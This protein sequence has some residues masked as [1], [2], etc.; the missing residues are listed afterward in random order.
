MN[1]P[2][3]YLFVYMTE[4]CMSSEQRSGVILILL[5]VTGFSFLP[6]F[7]RFIYES[8]TVSPLD[9]GLL[10]Y[11]LAAPM[12]WVIFAYRRAQ[13]SRRFELIQFDVRLL[14]LGILLAL[15]GMCAFFGFQ[16]IQASTYVLLFYSY[17]MFV[18]LLSAVLG[19]RLP[20]QA[21][22]ALILTMIG[23]ALTA[24]DFSAGLNGD[25]FVGAVLAIMNAIMAAVYFILSN[26]LMKR[27]T[28]LTYSSALVVSGA[29]VVF[30]IISLFRPVA[31]PD[32][33]P[34]WLY[35]IGLAAFSTVLPIFTL[36]AG[37]QKLGPSQS[38]ILATVEPLLTAVL[39]MVLLGETVLTIQW[40]GGILIVVSVIWLQLS[41]SEAKQ[42]KLDVQS[43]PSTV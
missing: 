38:A 24:P 27:Q 33:V 21:W 25:S 17:P 41:A 39:A 26:R 31:V 32:T 6:V 29:C 42:K 1:L 10:R 8:S 28:S 37:I 18:A 11:V 34:V 9:L 13:Q 35:V 5:S 20:W 3:S 40:I 36:N 22:V 2:Q 12:L 43:S 16:L 14:A 19:E 15:E 23:V 7:T 4:F 30:I